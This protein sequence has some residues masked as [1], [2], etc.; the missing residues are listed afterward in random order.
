MISVPGFLELI[1]HLVFSAEHNILET[2]SVSTLTW[3]D[4]EAMCSV[5]HIIKS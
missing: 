3:K 2:G 4:V 1:H 5:R